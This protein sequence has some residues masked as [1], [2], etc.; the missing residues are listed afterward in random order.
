MAN[1]EQF[2]PKQGSDTIQNQNNE[3]LR[4][5]LVKVLFELD[6]LSTRISKLEA[7]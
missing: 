1:I 7:K 2:N 3:A 6:A 4:A 5:I